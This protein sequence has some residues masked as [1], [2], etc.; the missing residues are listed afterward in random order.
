MYYTF[1]KNRNM[2]QKF[3]IGDTVK[4]ISG[5]PDMTIRGLHYDV[6][7][8]EYQENMFDCIWFDKNKD[9][10][11]AIY[12]C[13]FNAAELMKAGDATNARHD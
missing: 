6:S 4:L 10:K 5:G 8:N 7:A 12:Y 2:A 11:K 9:G 1:G 3:I 13:P